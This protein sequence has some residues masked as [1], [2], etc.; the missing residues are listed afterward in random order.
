[1]KRV[2]TESMNALSGKKAYVG[3]DVHKDSWH[4]F[5]NKKWFSCE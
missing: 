5:D 4:V 1:M 2:S 3:I